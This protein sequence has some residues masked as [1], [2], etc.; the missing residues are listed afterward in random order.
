MAFADEITEVKTVKIKTS[1]CDNPV[2]L[3][4]INK[5]GGNSFWLF[6][7]NQSRKTKTN[8]TDFYEKY[9]DN[10][11]NTYS[12]TFL[13]SKEAQHTITLLSTVEEEDMDGIV[14]LYESPRVFMLVNPTTWETVGCQ[15]QSVIVKEGSLVFLETNKSSF[16]VAIE[17]L[18]PKRYNQHE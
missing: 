1:N 13:I 17:I 4:W 10:L 16:D 9:V 12:N 11:S 8:N 18:L 2:F 14:G 7:R 15:W 3:R 6:N 5:Q